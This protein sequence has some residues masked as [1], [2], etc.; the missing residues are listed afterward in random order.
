MPVGNGG[1][2]GESLAP[3]AI[4]Q[5]ADRVAELQKK[6]EQLERELARD[7][8]VLQDAL[9]RDPQ[10]LC[11]TSPEDEILYVN[12]A[13]C[14]IFGFSRA[15]LIGRKGT[16][17]MPPDHCDEGMARYFAS[18]PAEREAGIPL[19]VRRTSG[20]PR[21]VETSTRLLTDEAGR[22]LAFV[23]RSVDVEKRDRIAQLEREQLE[24]LRALNMLAIDL[25][26]APLGTDLFELVARETMS[27]SG[28]VAT[29]IT[30][31]DPQASR[32]RVRKVV[33]RPSAGI[34][35]R[36]V[37]E[38]VTP[39]ELRVTPALVERMLR[40]VVHEPADLREMSLGSMSPE[41][42][43]QLMAQ[44]KIGAI[45]GLALNHGGELVGTAV[46]VMPVGARMLQTE[47]LHVLANMIAVTMRR[48]MAEEA[49]HDTNDLFS[50][51]LDHFPSLAWIKDT[52]HR[53]LFANG[54]YQQAAG[55]PIA[56]LVGRRAEEIWPPQTA[57]LIRDGDERVAR[58]NAVYEHELSLG[59]RTYAAYKFPVRRAGKP[60]LFGG[61]LLDVTDS[62]QAEQA[63]RALETRA[64]QSQ[65][66]ESLGVLA[67][68]IAHDFNNLL[69]SILGHASLALA[70]L[71]PDAPA[72]ASVQQVIDSAH[73]AAELT[74]QMLAF[75]GHGSI[76][77]RLLD[78]SASI[79][80]MAPL[81]E[82]SV[83]KKAIVEQRLAHDL[84][85]IASDPTQLR[86][87][88]I[89]LATNA[90]EAIGD[91]QGRITIST[92]LMRCS[93]AF[94]DQAQCEGH[95]P[96][97]YYVCLTVSDTGC[98][99]DEAVAPKIF[100][101]FF[102]T[103]FT[104]RGLGLAAVLGIV[105]AHHG[106]IRVESRPGVGTTFQVLLPPCN[107][108]AEAL[109]RKVEPAGSWHGSGLALVAD[110]E[111]FVRASAVRI[112]KRA[113]FE[114]VSAGDGLEAIDQAR[115]HGTAVRLV[116]LDASMPRVDGLEAF[117][118]IRRLCPEAKVILSS[119]YT[120]QEITG[121]LPEAEVDG[122]A[123]KPYGVD[124]LMA[125]V[126]KAF[127]PSER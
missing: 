66:L 112:L 98:G 18:S 29:I 56:R 106:G 36:Q 127:E 28:A 103:K 124:D 13:T 87:I 12:A 1:R 81:L 24:S 100:E 33:V 71:P 50:L 64:L 3:A 65:K 44:L 85:Q 95:L 39:L 15:E 104:G 80:E 110:D 35:E 43:K 32:L 16:G 120:E 42:S 122:F 121:K 77:L 90:S 69:T 52:D 4:A 118:E 113:G 61:F 107:Q 114:V 67:G 94:L 19:Y 115:A 49:L 34:P 88:L 37:Q 51:F 68:G 91:R 62:R 111:D 41:Q 8:A 116:L 26:A 38:I 10:P 102:T 48:M 73:D 58:D 74:R 9:D 82:I 20:P 23:A 105:R 31:Y 108:R 14:S 101:P 70:D 123:Q 5:L 97:G 92:S 25:A 125:V 59:G 83:S 60:P 7:R 57:A 126:R 99:I 2:A 46:L 54:R 21:L 11:V 96:E 78:L 119:G 53:V 63:R 30:L 27:I 89:A 72:R 40:E 75:A 84:P 47:A 17:L 76:N 117:R 45:R 79:E 86:Q 93:R 109:A 22:R 6:H 55:M